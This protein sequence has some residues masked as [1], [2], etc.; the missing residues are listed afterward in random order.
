MA[1]PTNQP[2]SYLLNLDDRE[3]PAVDLTIA[4]QLGIVD[5]EDK[6]PDYTPHETDKAGVVWGFRLFV[7]AG[8]D[9]DYNDRGHTKGSQGVSVLIPLDALAGY[10]ARHPSHKAFCTGGIQRWERKRNACRI[11]QA[12]IV[13]GVY[14]VCQTEANEDGN[15]SS[16]VI[17]ANTTNSARYVG[18]LADEEIVARLYAEDRASRDHLTTAKTTGKERN[19]NLIRE[20]LAPLARTMQG[21]NGRQRAAFLADVIQYLSTVKIDDRP[22]Y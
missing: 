4:D 5:P 6:R 13:G 9:L 2:T 21:L 1:T 22:N 15:Y 19:R 14:W 20:R 12:P 18:R 17:S 3:A 16:K 8:T 10:L 11:V 7:H